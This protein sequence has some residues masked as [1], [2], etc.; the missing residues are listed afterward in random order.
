MSL[1]KAINEKYRQCTHD[2]VE[3]GS[4]AQQ[5]ARS[6][7]TDWPLHWV[8]GHSRL[9]KAGLCNC[10]SLM[11]KTGPRGAGK[12]ICS[13]LQDASPQGDTSPGSTA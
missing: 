6:I 3:K 8:P 4:A 2:I 13:P 11:V 7:S 12:G 1:R 9:T 5:I 10:A